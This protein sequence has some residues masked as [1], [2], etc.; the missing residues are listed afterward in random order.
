MFESYFV[1]VCFVIRAG[2]GVAMCF[3][4]VVSS[5]IG[6]RSAGPKRVSEALGIIFTIRAACILVGPI[7]G[8]I[9]F[10]VGATLRQACLPQRSPS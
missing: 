3:V 4:E 8:G 2:Q 6:L 1:T 10:Q 9:L 7:L 5:T